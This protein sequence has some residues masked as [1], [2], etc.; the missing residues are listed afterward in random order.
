MIATSKGVV[1]TGTVAVPAVL[2]SVDRRHRVRAPVADIG[3]LVL[4]GVI[5]TLLCGLVPT[6]TVALTVLVE[7]LITETVPEP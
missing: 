3:Q 1:P 5:A 4:S 7:V 6:V 2:G